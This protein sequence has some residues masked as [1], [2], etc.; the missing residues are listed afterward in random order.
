MDIGVVIVTYNRIE[1]LKIALE[2]YDNQTYMP[3]YVLVV[4]NNSTDGT[5]EYLEEW[6]NEKKAYK[7]YVINLEENIGGSGGFYTGLEQARKLSSNW[8][9]VSDD[10]AFPKEDAF[11]KLNNLSKKVDVTKYSAICGK[12]INNGKID[13]EHRRTITTGIFKIKEKSVPIEEYSKEYFTLNLFSYVGT[14]IN[15]E[16]I[17]K[18]GATIKDFFI[19][20]DDT[21]HSYRLSTYKPIICVPNVEIIHNTV[22][23]NNVTWKKYYATRNRLIFYKKHFSKRHYY[24]IYITQ[25]LK[26]IVVKVIKKAIGKN[27]VVNEMKIKAIKD[28]KKDKLGLDNLYKPGWKGSI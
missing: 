14:I 15:K 3:E 27:Y 25:Y 12:V 21:E 23:D 1:K 26:Q 19:Y 5:Y 11:E 7:K 18:C 22:S 17:K 24:Y 8:I 16:C 9:W 2:K 10:D 4:N 20:Y 28:V 13:L 6:K